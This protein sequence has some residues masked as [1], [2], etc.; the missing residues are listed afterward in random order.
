MLKADCPFTDASSFVIYSSF[1]NPQSV[2]SSSASSPNSVS[3]ALYISEG[4]PSSNICPSSA[5]PGRPSRDWANLAWAW[6]SNSQSSPCSQASS[7]N[8]LVGPGS[9][10][11][12]LRIVCAL[13]FDACQI[14]E[15]LFSN[16]RFGF[17]MSCIDLSFARHVH[18]F[19]SWTIEFVY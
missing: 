13:S 3:V 19:L 17:C 7:A 2:D 14:P 8:L 18:L 4:I 12:Q 6:D 11:L 9:R 16:W 15:F 10:S 1:S 5:N